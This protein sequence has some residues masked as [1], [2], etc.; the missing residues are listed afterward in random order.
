MADFMAKA[1]IARFRIEAIQ[2][3]LDSLDQMDFSQVD[4]RNNV[5]FDTGLDLVPVNQP[6]TPST[7][8]PIVV[9][10]P[11][12]LPQNPPAPE[13]DHI[14]ILLLDSFLFFW[15]RKHDVT[16]TT[17]VLLGGV[18]AADFQQH[19]SMAPGDIVVLPRVNSFAVLQDSFLDIFSSIIVPSF[20]NIHRRLSTTSLTPI[21]EKEAS[22][23]ASSA[24]TMNQAKLLPAHIWY[25]RHQLSLAYEG[26]KQTAANLQI[27]KLVEAAHASEILQGPLKPHVTRLSSTKTLAVCY[28]IWNHVDGASI[29]DFP[30]PNDGPITKPSEVASALRNFKLYSSHLHGLSMQP[31]I[32]A[33][34]EKVTEI[35]RIWTDIPVHH[36][37]TLVDAVL[38]K[39]R[40]VPSDED[41]PELVHAQ[42]MSIASSLTW[43]STE[44][45]A[46]M[47][48][49]PHATIKTSS[50]PSTDPSPAPP[51]KRVRF[52]EPCPFTGDICWNWV[53]QKPNCKDLICSL[54]PPRPHVWP[55]GT[56]NLIK[57]TLKDWIAKKQARKS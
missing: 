23:H 36:L 15:I 1:A 28:G 50:V 19:T 52:E 43:N 44:M 53:S 55:P 46:F 14:S 33:L 51:T 42:L 48:Q 29:H 39:F 31:K 20:S 34:E 24:Q 49:R 32:F 37:I 38:N 2:P 47:V 30:H 21:H 26:K 17:L 41:E 40:S 25:D 12:R 7:E 8:P 45:I 54:K 57:Q 5:P 18:N 27:D 4:C 56:S 10:C 22:Q 3:L 6:I 16:S 13:F 9:F 35:T 11:T